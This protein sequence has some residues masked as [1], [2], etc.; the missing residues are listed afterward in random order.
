MCGPTVAN[1][2]TCY[3]C[4]CV[5]ERIKLVQLTYLLSGSSRSCGCLRRELVAARWRI[6]GETRDRGATRLYQTWQ[7]MLARCYRPSNN[8][9]KDYGDRGIIVCDTWRHDYVAFRDWALSSGYAD[10]L[11][12]DRKD[13]NGPYAPENCRWSTTV[14]Q[15]NN[16]RGNRPVLAWGETKTVAQW[17]RDARC[18]VTATRLRARL[19]AG[20]TPEDAVATTSGGIHRSEPPDGTT[21]AV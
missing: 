20:W 5:C 8:S 15:A 16:R 18:R 2:K 19:H 12:I 21:Q 13:N 4:R 1:G 10:K 14:E 11:T 6:H 9:Y 7:S 3:Q 17:A